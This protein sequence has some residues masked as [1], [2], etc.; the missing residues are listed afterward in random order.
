MLTEDDWELLLE[1][2][3]NQKCTPFLGAESTGRVMPSRSAIAK[4]WAEEV[5]FPLD[6]SS[7]LSRVAQFIATKRDPLEPRDKL[8]KEIEKIPTPDFKAPD[9]PHG[10][11]AGLPL[12]VYITTDYHNFMFAALKSCLK[13]ARQ[14]ICRWNDLVKTAPSAFDSGFEPNVANPVVF[15]FYGRAAVQESLVLTEDDYLEFLVETSKEAKRIPPR[16]QEAFT[17]TSLLFLGYRLT[18]LEFRVLLRTL[19]GYLER[20]MTRGHVSAQLVHVGDEPP[21]DGQVARLS[22]IQEYLSVYCK[23]FHITTYWG[24]TR[25]FLVELKQRWEAFAK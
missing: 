5:D 22:K 2:I 23:G 19:A 17:K 10:I 13:D 21:T 9:E 6:D 25:D 8:V 12:P 15:H 4:R 3:R 1:R 14:E 18:D 7:D 16:I 20:S 24:T 11:L